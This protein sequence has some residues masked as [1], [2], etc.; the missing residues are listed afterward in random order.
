M[1]VMTGDRP[2]T[3]AA[4]CLLC[5][6]CSIW[7][8]KGNRNSKWQQDYGETNNAPWQLEATLTART[9]TQNKHTHTAGHEPTKRM[10]SRLEP[11]HKSHLTQWQATRRC[12][13]KVSV[14]LTQTP[15]PVL[16]AY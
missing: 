11:S 1:E 12:S 9:S 13:H 16:T 2:N 6:S 8:T 10:A 3:N 15:L 5:M 4:A 7:S 14:S